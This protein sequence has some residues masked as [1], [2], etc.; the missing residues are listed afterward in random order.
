MA[1]LDFVGGAG[2]DGLTTDAVILDGELAAV[3]SWSVEVGRRWCPNVLTVGV[4][5]NG[6]VVLVIGC[7]ILIT[8]C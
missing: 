2:E 8:E 1:P 4:N 7:G 3:A 6:A 5:G